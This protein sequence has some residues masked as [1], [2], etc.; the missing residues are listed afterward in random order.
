MFSSLLLPAGDWPS[1]TARP[2]EGS[3]APAA[4]GIWLAIIVARRRACEYFPG[5]AQPVTRK[6]ASSGAALTYNATAPEISK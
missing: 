3:P 6:M 1:A 2:R 4:I 5:V